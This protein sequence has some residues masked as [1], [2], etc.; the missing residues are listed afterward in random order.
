ML[1]F[2]F[3]LVCVLMF[4]CFLAVVAL[5]RFV[6][7]TATGSSNSYERQGYTPT[8]DEG[9]S[10]PA[11][12]PPVSSYDTRE[13]ERL[14]ISYGSNTPVSVPDGGSGGSSDP[15][16]SFGGGSFGGGGSAESYDNSSSDSSFSSSSSCSSS[17]CSGGSSCGGGSSGD[18]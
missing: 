1:F 17:S 2:G 13:E 4:L 6:W 11:W 7:R 12:N 16:P 10:T 3:V 14:P 8:F 5:I 18:Y 9:P 15:A